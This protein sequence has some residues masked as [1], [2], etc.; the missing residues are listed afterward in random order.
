EAPPGLTLARDRAEAARIADATAQGVDS[1][2]LVEDDYRATLDDVELAGCVAWSPAAATA[3]SATSTAGGPTAGT[4][5]TTRTDKGYR[6]V[7]MK[8]VIVRWYERNVR[9]DGHA[10]ADLLAQVEAY[11]LPTGVVIVVAHGSR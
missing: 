5:S 11:A 10:L 3:V 4:G 6:G 1:H 2:F 7:G 9:R 8:C